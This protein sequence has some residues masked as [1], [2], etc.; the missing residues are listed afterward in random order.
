MKLFVDVTLQVQYPDDGPLHRNGD[1]DDDDDAAMKEWLWKHKKDEILSAMKI[2]KEPIGPHSIEQRLKLLDT[3][4]RV[5]RQ[6]LQCEE[7][8]TVVVVVQVVSCRFLCFVLIRSRQSRMRD[9][10]H[11][12]LFPL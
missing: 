1:A 4:S 10:T 12:H 7:V 5:Q 2:T 9:L 3:I 11:M 6:Y 8:R